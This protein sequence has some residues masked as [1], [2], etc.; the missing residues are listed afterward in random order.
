MSDA[1]GGAYSAAFDRVTL[2]DDPTVLVVP[3]YALLER[4]SFLA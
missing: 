1:T 3:S 4:H 2:A